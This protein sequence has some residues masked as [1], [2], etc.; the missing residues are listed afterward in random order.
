MKRQKVGGKGR[1]RGAEEVQRRTK[2]ALFATD[3]QPDKN[4]RRGSERKERFGGKSDQRTDQ[5]EEFFL[6]TFPPPLI[7]F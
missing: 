3:G 6:A 1:G 2:M 4:R 5:L 7:H